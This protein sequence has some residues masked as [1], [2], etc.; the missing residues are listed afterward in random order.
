MLSFK[1][2]IPEAR[3]IGVDGTTLKGDKNPVMRNDG[4]FT[5]EIELSPWRVSV[6]FYDINLLSNRREML[7]PLLGLAHFLVTLNSGQ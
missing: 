6:L 5:D 3:H 7:D 4:N 2:T 1:N